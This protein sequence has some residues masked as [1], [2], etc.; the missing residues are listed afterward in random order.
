MGSELDSW[1]QRYDYKGFNMKKSKNNR[2]VAEPQPDN[3]KLR[4]LSVK[5]DRAY[6]RVVT[7]DRR[8]VMR[9]SVPV[10]QWVMRLLEQFTFGKTGTASSRAPRTKDDI[11]C[12]YLQL[13]PISQKM[14]NDFRRWAS[15]LLKAEHNYRL[16]VGSRIAELVRR[17]RAEEH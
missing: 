2:W 9:L 7:P 4:K 12:C 13:Q 1:N 3:F 11:K 10:R 6:M 8:R 5:L 15:E 16:A 17:A 14:A